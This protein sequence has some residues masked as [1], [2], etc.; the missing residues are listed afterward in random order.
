MECRVEGRGWQAAENAVKQRSR[1]QQI[2]GIQKSGL[3]HNRP[4]IFEWPLAC[5]CNS[6]ARAAKTTTHVLIKIKSAW[7]TNVF[8]RPT[9]LQFSTITKPIKSWKISNG[10]WSYNPL[11][12]V[13]RMYKHD[14]IIVQQ[15]RGV[16]LSTYTNSYN[17]IHSVQNINVNKTYIRI[18]C[19]L[20]RLKKE[21][22][23][24]IQCSV[25][26]ASYHQRL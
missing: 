2:S 26:E 18:K 17:Y 21:R 25:W 6:V 8:S 20:T 13:N 10:S 16:F 9:R 12:Y 3:F 14:L 4:L 1:S 11:N 24:I 15:E 7:T 19:M 23:I 22:Y 5:I